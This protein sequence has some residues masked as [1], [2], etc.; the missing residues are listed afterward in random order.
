MCG[1]VIIFFKNAFAVFQCLQNTPIV[2]NEINIINKLCNTF[3]T[4]IP[5]V[6]SRNTMP[7][8]ENIE[9]TKAVAIS[10]LILRDTLSL[11]TSYTKNQAVKN[12]PIPRSTRVR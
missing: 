7:K 8:P 1:N 9:A 12:T 6:S 11:V 3:Y 2:I 5:T 4:Y 10:F